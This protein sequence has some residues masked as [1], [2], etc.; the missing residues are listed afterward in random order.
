MRFMRY[1]E[2]GQDNWVYSIE[3]TLFCV[4]LLLVCLRRVRKLV[5]IAL[6]WCGVLSCDV[7]CCGVVRCVPIE[8]H[9]HDKYHLLLQTVV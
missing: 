7:V 9:L 4:T 1:L 6:V 8:T 3:K 2:S 5:F